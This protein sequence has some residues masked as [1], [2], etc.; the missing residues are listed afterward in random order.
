[1]PLFAYI[2]SRPN[3]A[4]LAAS[5]SV[6]V[7]YGGF[8]ITRNALNDPFLV[9]NHKHENPYPW[10]SVPQDRNLKLYA[11]NRKFEKGG[12]KETYLDK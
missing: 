1:M 5:V 9:V 10:L 8:L 11:V 3:Y 6:G 2:K 12:I 4:I 7:A